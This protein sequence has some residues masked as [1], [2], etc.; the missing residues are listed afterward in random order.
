MNEETKVVNIEEKKVETPQEEKEGVITLSRPYKF[1]GKDYTEIDLS[2][3]EKLKVQDAI[4][5][6]KQLFNPAGLI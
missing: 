6:Q 5:A 4:D 1:E 2:G 3:I